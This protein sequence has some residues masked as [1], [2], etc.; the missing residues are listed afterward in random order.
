VKWP[1]TTLC[2]AELSLFG[3]FY[4]D[5]FFFAMRFRCLSR[6]I[7][8]INERRR[9]G[10]ARNNLAT[11]SRWEGVEIML[12]VVVRQSPPIR[13]TVCSPTPS[14]LVPH[15]PFATTTRTMYGELYSRFWRDGN[16]GKRQLIPEIRRR[17]QRRAALQVVHSITWTEN[18]VNDD[19]SDYNGCGPKFCPSPN[20]SHQTRCVMG[21]G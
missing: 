18:N 8:G 20:L 12:C 14:A 9:V 19:R 2:D 15:A 4:G 3:N 7:V 11:E 6:V 16:G 1:R 13:C 17:I 10:V 21:T 5:D